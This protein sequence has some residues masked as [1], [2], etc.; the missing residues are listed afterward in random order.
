MKVRVDDE[1]CKREGKNI[2][3]EAIHTCSWCLQEF[4]STEAFEAHL[5]DGKTIDPETGNRRRICPN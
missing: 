1:R 2:I 3:I 4:K 5:V